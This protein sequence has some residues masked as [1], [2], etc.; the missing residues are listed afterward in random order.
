MEAKDLIIQRLER[1]VVEL[2]ARID[3]LEAEVARLRKN[4]GNSSKPPSSDIVKPPK[5]EPDDKKRRG[6][7]AKRK[8]GG[9]PGH[10][11]HDRKA[12]GQHEVDR[13]VEYEL[14]S[15]QARFLTPLD[16]W[17]IIQQVELV[18]RPLLITEYRARLT[19][20]SGP[21]GSSPRRF[22]LLL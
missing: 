13:I 16:Q 1:L 20:T 2:S 19:A 11:K 8:Q 17:R 15:D 6:R 7:K 18:D 10:K 9:Q 4:S 12:F 3:E 14:S 22:Q 5:P 21:V